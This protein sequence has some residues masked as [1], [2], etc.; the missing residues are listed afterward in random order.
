MAAGVITINRKK[1]AVGLF[2]QPLPVGQNPFNFSK[3]LA[4]KIPGKIKF[5]TDFKS[6]V[7]IGSRIQG[8]HRGMKIA[9]V[10]LMDYFSEYNSFL[11]EFFT[12]QG[13]WIIGVRNNIIVFDQLFLSEANA[14][15]E[16]AKLV[17][18]PD[19]DVV[20]ASG[21]WNIPRAEEKTLND[22][23]TGHSKPYLN[24]VSG[25]F[26]HVFA[27][28]LFFATVFGMW[29]L[30]NE[31]IM[32]MF[33]SRPQQVQI[34]PEILK[35]YKKQLDAKQAEIKE[36]MQPQVISR[37]YDSLPDPL[38][39]A[40]QCWR[41]IGFVMQPISGW[42]QQSAICEENTAKVTL[43]RTYGTLDELYSSAN[44]LMGD[45][46]SIIKN[47]DSDIIISVGLNSLQ[48]SKDNMLDNSAED[49]IFYINNTFQKIGEFVNIKSE[50]ETF[51]Q[52]QSS[53]TVNI[54]I[55]NT[56]SKLK[57]NEFIKMFNGIYPMSLSSVKWD[58]RSRT[59]N[60]EVK[61]YAK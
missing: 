52:G 37:P 17:G 4:K 51:G 38:L 61:I 53:E 25:V 46:I 19:W 45:N 16:F 32:K 22:I 12:P 35:E 5:Y 28:I 1:Y 36:A 23:I 11:A 41:A 48:P 47:T 30:F 6:M 43:R 56:N 8:H 42:A 34:N 24:P 9:A 54:I 2:W 10:E 49:I 15:Q 44:S 40:D 13:F 20:I 21:S 58:A 59:W 39:R 50:M 31:P 33:T 14:K 3:Q 29:Y 7:G 26:G 27:L 18:L 57:P 55:V 60:Y